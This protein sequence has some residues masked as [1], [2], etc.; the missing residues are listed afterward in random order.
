MAG[1]YIGPD[2][3]QKGITGLIERK[4]DMVAEARLTVENKQE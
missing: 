4:G 3:S 1:T 2:L